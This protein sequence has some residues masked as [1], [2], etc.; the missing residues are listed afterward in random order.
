MSTLTASY[1]EPSKALVIAA[2]AAVY[3]LWGSTYLAIF[4]ALNDIRPF[5]LVSRPLF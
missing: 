5:L 3:I 2:F 4:I 1:K